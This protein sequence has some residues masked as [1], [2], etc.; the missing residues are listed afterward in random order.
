MNI[1]KA[2]GTPGIVPHPKFPIPSPP[3][4]NCNPRFGILIP[5]ISIL[6]TCAH[7]FTEYIE[8]WVFLVY[9]NNIMQ[10]V[11]FINIMLLRFIHVVTCR[12]SSFIVTAL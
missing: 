5:C 11:N 2:V 3:R 7:T 12:S 4:S 1:T 8:L 6:V 10:C 9:I